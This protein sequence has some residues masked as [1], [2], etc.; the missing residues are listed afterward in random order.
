MHMNRLQ[1]LLN[2][3]AHFVTGWNNRTSSRKLMTRCQWLDI[4]EMS[5]YFLIIEGWKMIWRQEPTIVMRRIEVDHHNMLL[6]TPAP[7]LKTSETSYRWRLMREFNSIRPSIR[8]IG[9]LNKFKAR[10]RK[11]II[12]MRP[13]VGGG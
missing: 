1:T 6:T 2:K 5:R 8:D 9:S 3:A 7:R 12:N 4:R 13:R 10:L 11:Y